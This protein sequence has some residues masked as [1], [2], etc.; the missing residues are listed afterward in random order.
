MKKYLVLLTMCL[1]LTACDKFS[2]KEQAEKNTKSAVI[3]NSKAQSVAD[4]GCSQIFSAIFNEETQSKKANETK[5]III[6]GA[7]FPKTITITFD[8]TP[9]I[10][11]IVRTGSITGVLT[12]HIYSPDALL[13][14]DYSNYVVN[15]ILFNGKRYI[16]NK[17]TTVSL[18]SIT[19]DVVANNTSI[20]INNEVGIWSGNHIWEWTPL[21]T[22]ST[23]SSNG[24]SAAGIA[25]STETITPLVQKIGCLLVS[26]GT[27]GVT[28][29]IHTATID[30]GNGI[31]DD[32][33]IFTFNGRSTEITFFY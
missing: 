17:N 20:A 6:S 13:T 15:G 24:V 30:F 18:T 31:C 32:K 5:T 8:G 1:T 29:G 11:G 25:Y 2:E 22:K 14:L 28:S 16:T 21:E 33:A 19:F 26:S 27:I 7:S 10:L 3:Y 9:D 12:D 4:D 23:G